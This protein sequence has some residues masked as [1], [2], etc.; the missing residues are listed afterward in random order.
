[1]KYKLR[2]TP[3][4]VFE[5]TKYMVAYAKNLSN[6]NFQPRMPR[7]DHEFLYRVIETAIKSEPLL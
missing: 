7:S 1:M 3:D 5:R 6:V 4:E 2:M